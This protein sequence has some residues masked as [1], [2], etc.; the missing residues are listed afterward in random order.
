MAYDTILFE[1]AGGVA[2]ITLNRP[3]TLNAFDDQMI[4]ETTD[5]FKQCRGSSVRAV[6]LT[7]SGRAFSSGQDLS[8]VSKREGEFSI[9][10]H[11][12][13]GYNHLIGQM[14]GLEKPI[15]GAINGVAAGAGCSVALATDIRIASDRASFIQVFSKV[16]LVPDSGSTWILPRL[17]GYARAYEMAATADKVSAEKALQWGLVNDVVPGDSLMEVAL[18]WANR[19]ASGPTLALG[20]TKRAMRRGLNT[21]LD[22]ALDYEASLQEVAA[23]SHDFGEGV[24]AF[25][26]K[27]PP[28][29]KG[30]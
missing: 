18:A 10:A 16:G 21:S 23:R 25:L 26:E 14:V 12:R 20:L 9:G 5:A 27:R 11:L 4:R 1:V 15:V 17:I 24:R 7:G 13:Q 8:D 22:E 19:L 6:L 28:E 2:T 3:A 30:E 29:Y